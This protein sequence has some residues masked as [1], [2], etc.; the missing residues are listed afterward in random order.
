MGETPVLRRGKGGA[1][2]AQARRLC[3][4]W[5]RGGAGE[6]PVLRLDKG[7]AGRCDVCGKGGLI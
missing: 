7:G 6:M 5:I 1:G 2:G 3:Y 4:A